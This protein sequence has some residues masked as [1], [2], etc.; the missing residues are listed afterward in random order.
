MKR[1]YIFY[2]L[3]SLSFYS[4]Q[5][6]EVESP[7][8]DV[9]PTSL[10][11]KLGDS[12]R[13]NFTG[14]TDFLTFYSGEQ[15]REYQYK[16]RLE[17]TGGTLFLEFVS[18]AL[19]ASEGDI[20]LLVS[21]N[22]NGSYDTTS[23]KN[24]TWTDISNRFTWA[25]P[26]PGGV[27]ANQESGKANISDLLV[28]GK[29]L[30]LA[31]QYKAA[32]PPTSVATQRTWRIF[33]LSMTNVF[34]DGTVATVSNLANAAWVNVDFKNPNNKWI[35]ANSY[36]QLAPNHIATNPL[37]TEDW[38]IS[39]PFNPN[40]VTPDRG[41]AIK[42]FSRRKTSHAYLYSKPGTYKVTFV[43]TNGTIDGQKSMVKELEITILP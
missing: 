17:L 35:Y 39:K 12:V 32:K 30:Y 8:F 18:R 38:A 13:F 24:A 34:P 3:L 31:Y 4:C 26:V 33:S 28:S 42:E 29:P 40:K 10:Q 2:L 37:A 23:V 1:N 19:Y 9:Q 14:D 5:D 20:K 41:V 36:L 25:T 27:G 21:T 6:T 7:S 16:D 11:Y 43:A 15:G 22:F